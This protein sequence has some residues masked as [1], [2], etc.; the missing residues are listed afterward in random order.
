MKKI[1]SVNA[2]FQADNQLA[3]YCDNLVLKPHQAVCKFRQSFVNS[4]KKYTKKGREEEKN[5]NFNE[6][7]L[8][9]LCLQKSNKAPPFSP[10]QKYP[11]SLKQSFLVEDLNVFLSSK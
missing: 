2:I 9:Q 11:L 8:N 3:D 6:K 4:D 1:I 10:P 7:C 5:K